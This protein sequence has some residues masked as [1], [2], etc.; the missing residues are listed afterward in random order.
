MLEDTLPLSTPS[1]VE[2]VVS[3]I[4]RP[5]PTKKRALSHDNSTPF[6]MP[7]IPQPFI[8]DPP[9]ANG[10]N[11]RILLNSVKT[12]D[13]VHAF[14]PRDTGTALLGFLERTNLKD[15]AQYCLSQ[16]PQLNHDSKNYEDTVEAFKFAFND[17]ISRTSSMLTK[18]SLDKYT[19]KLN[20][21]HF[22]AFKLLRKRI[23]DFYVPCKHLLLKLTN[24]TNTRDYPQLDLAFSYQG[25]TDEMK[26]SCADEVR[27]L[28]VSLEHK[29]TLSAINRAMP[30]IEETKETYLDSNMSDEQTFLLCKAFRAVIL[31]YRDIS[32]DILGFLPK[33][34]RTERTWVNSR[35][36]RPYEQH[37]K[38]QDTRS[39]NARPD[40]ARP[41]RPTRYQSPVRRPEYSRR[42]YHD[43]KREERRPADKNH[44]RQYRYERPERLDSRDQRQAPRRD[45]TDN[46]YYDEHFP[47]YDNTHKQRFSHRHLSDRD[48]VFV[49]EGRPSYTTYRW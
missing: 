36:D 40:T 35:R 23:T 31:R 6:I 11:L 2:P 34:P 12:G 9:S 49:R 46:R 21:T 5:A 22:E 20:S 18:Y 28:K 14:L 43:Y 13:Y 42:E 32:K 16:A 4:C 3:P 39:H 25:V 24:E 26:A 38:L 44:D 29:L 15:S 41:P 48:E 33:P 19:E 37:N 45:S 47:P 17:H 27:K 1:D 30:L 10:D 7:H 8:L